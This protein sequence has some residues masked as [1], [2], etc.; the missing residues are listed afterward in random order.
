MKNFLAGFRH[1]WKG[2]SLAFI[3]ERN[4][5]IHFA[6]ATLTIAG[7]FYCNITSTEWCIIIL[8]IGL[9]LALELINTAIENLTD[10]VTQEWKPLAGKV[11]DVAAGAVLIASLSALII[12]VILFSKYLI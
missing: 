1:A 6:I 4:V 10:L 12:G 3:S 7:G 5:K 2:I 8:C 11:K 9:V